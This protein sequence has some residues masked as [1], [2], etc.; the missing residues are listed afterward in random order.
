M[1]TL[2]RD[3]PSLA[4]AVASGL[5]FAVVAPS[6]GWGQEKHRFTFKTPAQTTEYT[7]QYVIDAKDIPG[8]QVRILEVHRTPNASDAPRYEGL[9]AVDIWERGYSDY[10]NGTGTFVVYIQHVL[11]NGDRIFWRTPGTT[12]T[13]VAPDGIKRTDVSYAATITGG[14]G[15]MRGIRGTM[16]GAAHLEFR[17]GRAVS[18]ESEGEVEYWFE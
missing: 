16:Q 12:R 14:T 5:V 2:A 18:N 4:L 3:G 10:T 8:H 7:Q 17:D 13:F 1:R 6:A 9:R 15:K 11:E